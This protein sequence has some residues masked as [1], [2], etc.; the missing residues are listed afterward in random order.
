VFAGRQDI[1]DRHRLRSKPA[2]G[3]I[4][5]AAAKVLT[6]RIRVHDPR[7]FL[8]C[9]GVCDRD[10]ETI[11]PRR[12]FVAYPIVGVRDPE[13]DRL[14]CPPEGYA[15]TG[16]AVSVDIRDVEVRDGVLLTGR[17]HWPAFTIGSS[18]ADDPILRTHEQGLPRS[19]SDVPTIV[20]RCPD[21][22]MAWN[23]RA[24]EKPRFRRRQPSKGFTAT[25]ALGNGTRRR[26][27]R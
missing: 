11:S 26:S 15:F 5:I 19:R 25:R 18:R 10:P 13:C 22:A 20:K 1:L 17:R 14:E 21:P 3:A 7:R 8:T 6:R 4:L 24:P 27:S 16:V 9:R 2:V 12:P 23:V